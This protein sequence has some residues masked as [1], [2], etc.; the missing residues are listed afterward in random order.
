MRCDV[1]AEGIIAAAKDLNINIPI[2]CRL[3]GTNVNEARD[4]IKKSGLRII[5]RHDLDE[6]ANLSVNLAKIIS[7]AREVNMGVQFEIP[8]EAK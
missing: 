3:Q 5:P 8:D 4:L 2:V 1:I 6:A 7:L